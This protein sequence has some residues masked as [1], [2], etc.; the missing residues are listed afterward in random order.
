MGATRYTYDMKKPL[1]GGLALVLVA[2]G[3]YFALHSDTKSE[4]LLSGAADYKNT[5]Y[6][7]GGHNVKLVDGVAS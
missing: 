5:E 4:P 7:I 1:I 2:I 6:M 3:G